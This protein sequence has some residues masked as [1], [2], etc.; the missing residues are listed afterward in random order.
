[1]VQ[2]AARYKEEDETHK[3]RI[4]A[5]NSLEHYAYSMRN[6]LNEK[7]G[8]NLGDGDKKTIDSAVQKTIEWLEQNQSADKIDYENKLKELEN[9]CNPI[10]TSMYQSGASTGGV[11][12]TGAGTATGGDNG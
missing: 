5:K 2:E 7:T 3:E 1:M 6:T 10:I 8:A 11:P 9:T 4:E 12:D